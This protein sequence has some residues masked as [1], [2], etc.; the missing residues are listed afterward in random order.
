[1][2]K[3]VG[4]DKWLYFATLAL[5]VIGLAMVFSASAVMARDRFGSPYYF[6]IRQ[7]LWAAVGLV[8]M[9]LLMRVNYGRYNKPTVVF[10][11]VGITII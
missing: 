4:V 6:L 7:S 11:M 9:T 5:V 8:S 10:P 3:R 1:M 2:A